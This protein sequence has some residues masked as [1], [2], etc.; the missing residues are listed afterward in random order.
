MRS[1]ALAFATLALLA[2]PASAQAQH[3][4]APVAHRDWSQIAVRTPE[5]G[6]RIG[7]PAA[8]VKLIEYGSITCPHCAAFSADGAAALRANYVRPGRV[9]WE[10]RPYVI[11]PTDPGIFTLLSCLPPS[12]FFPAAEQLYATQQTWV[13]RV[14]ALPE[15]QLQQ[16]QTLTPNQ[17][18]AALV[19]AAG[20]D[21][22][23]RAQGLGPAQ[24]NA[25]LASPAGLHRIGAITQH[26]NALGVQG[27]PTFFINGRSV[28]TQSWARLEPMLRGG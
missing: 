21:V 22:F 20:L 12:R 2:A 17:Q 8:P 18:A 26:A 5:G 13:G 14:Q 11:F 25:C 4:R 23:F 28:G 6:V 15:A 3:R 24:A 7:N 19:R 9:S 1:F 27:T 10:Y 16:L